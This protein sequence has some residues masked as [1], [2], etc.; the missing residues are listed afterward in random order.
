MEK[1]PVT[2]DQMIHMFDTQQKAIFEINKSHTTAINARTI[3]EIDRVAEKMNLMLKRQ[4]TANNNIA[5]NNKTT[6][7]VDRI[8]K[9]IKWYVLGLFGFMYSTCWIYNTFNLQDIILKLIY[10]I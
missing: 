6:E 5:K 8:N 3:S 2:Y 1:Q 4:A 10:K 7:R 9:N